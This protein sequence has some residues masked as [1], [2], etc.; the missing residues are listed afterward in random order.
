MSRTWLLPG[1]LLFPVVEIVLLILVG[2]AIGGGLTVVLLLAGALVGASLMRKEGRRAW[3]AL[4]GAAQSGRMPDR[5]LGDSAMVMAGGALLVIPGFLSDLVGIFLL[6]PVTRPIARRGL[7]WF[8][9]RR[10][11]AM[12]A[13]SPYGPL[14][15]RADGPGA[16]GG[17]GRV[18]HGEVIQDDEVIEGQ[19]V[20]QR[21][22]PRQDP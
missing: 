2:Q 10:V 7:A 17:A 13:R 22:D 11:D 9:G 4:Q 20:V 1:L 3:A 18:V 8:V 6:L 14:F 19:I 16:P 12:A 21:R 5:E 15:D